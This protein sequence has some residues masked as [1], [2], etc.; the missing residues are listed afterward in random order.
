MADAPPQPASDTAVLVREMGYSEAEWLRVLPAAL[1][2]WTWHLEDRKA[3]VLA[4]G[5]GWVALTWSPMLPRRLGLAVLPRME[6]VF[7]HSG[8]SEPEFADWL[9]LFDL[10][11]RRGGG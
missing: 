3:L 2:H 6:V 10:Y 5:G 11:T 9:A 4:P 8:L 1:G 7:R